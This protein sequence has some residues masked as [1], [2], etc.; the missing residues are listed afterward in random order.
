MISVARR[1][2]RRFTR[3]ERGAALI[4]F[5]LVLPLLLVLVSGIIDFG[6]ALFMLNNLTNSARAGARF[7]A[8]KATS[9]VE[10]AAF[11][12]SVRT[13]VRDY[14]IAMESDAPAVTNDM[15]GITLTPNGPQPQ[16]IAVTIQDYPF[17]A[18]TP[19]PALVGMDDLSM[20]AVT[21][22]FRWEGAP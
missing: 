6:R 19:L 8:A 7:A 2:A 20:P 3:S 14:I 10:T 18:I 16:T 9:D 21:V 4:E 17:N 1:I 15:I 13:F 11:Q 5:A 12:D 22:T